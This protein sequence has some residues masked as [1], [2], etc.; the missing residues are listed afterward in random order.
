MYDDQQRTYGA[1]VFVEIA[2]RVSDIFAASLSSLSSLLF[3]FNHK[4][5]SVLLFDIQCLTYNKTPS[6]QA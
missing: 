2:K 1:L 5:P 3:I 6:S 4:I